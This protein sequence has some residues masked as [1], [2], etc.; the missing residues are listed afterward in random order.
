M[1]NAHNEKTRGSSKGN[2]ETSASRFRRDWLVV[3]VAAVGL[4]VAATMW[5][6]AARGML[7]G[8]DSSPAA[9]APAASAPE[10]VSP[11]FTTA[12]RSLLSAVQEYFGV[13]GTPVQPIQFNHSIHIKNGQ[14][15]AGCHSGVTQGP[16]AGIP[17]VSFCMAC[18]QAIA[19]DK[20]EIKK[21]TAYAAKGREP[22]WQPVFWFYPE[23]HV[24]FRHAPH[25]RN[26]IA[27]EQCHGDLSKETVAVRSKELTMNFCLTCHKANAVSVDCVTCHY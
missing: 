7:Q 11:V 6:G 26:G 9:G 4:G 12:R 16:D 5:V 1:N 13:Q 24:R 25:I 18:H 23:V 14:Q 8:Q 20:P 17:S 21:L 19:T 27:C 10:Q 22:P 3:S 2:E 15:C